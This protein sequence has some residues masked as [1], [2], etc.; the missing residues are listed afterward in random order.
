M[1][2]AVC[3]FPSMNG[4]PWTANNY[5]VAMLFMCIRK[6]FGSGIEIRL[7]DTETKQHVKIW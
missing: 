4:T 5:I 2:Y 7:I 6:V 3:S 1:R